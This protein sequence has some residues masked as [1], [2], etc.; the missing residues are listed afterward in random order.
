MITPYNPPKYV[1]RILKKK[2]T[3]TPQNTPLDKRTIDDMKEVIII[4]IKV[5]MDLEMIR[6][7][8]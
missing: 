5:E 7:R 4:V 6:Y 2:F 8:L 3:L 1:S